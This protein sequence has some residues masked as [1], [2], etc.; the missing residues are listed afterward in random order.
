[1]DFLDFACKSLLVTLSVDEASER[2]VEKRKKLVV[3]L[4]SLGLLITIDV[5]LLLFSSMLIYMIVV[6][7]V[8]FVMVMIIMFVSEET[9]E[10]S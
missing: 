5:F 2:P 6:K 3:I 10:S 9:L 1:M 8:I 4:I 7:V